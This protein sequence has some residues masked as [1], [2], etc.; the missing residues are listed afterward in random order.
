LGLPDEAIAF[1]VK[2]QEISTLFESDHYLYF[3]SLAGMGYT[4]FFTGDSKKA[5]EVGKT[6]LD[7]GQKHSNIRSQVVGHYIMGYGYYVG[8][9][10]PK[11]IE[12]CQRAIRL[13]TDPLYSQLPKIILG[14]SYLLN[15]QFEDAKKP[16]EE[17]VTFSKKFG[18]EL[19]ETPAR[20]LLAAI[21]IAEGHMSSGLTKLKEIQGECLKNQRKGVYVMFEH[22]LGKIYLQI[23]EGPSPSLSIVIKN[24]G[25]LIK[26]VPFAGRKAE[27]HLKKAIEAAKEIGAKGVL[28]QAY[29]D[30]GLLHKIKRRNE[31]ARECIS[32]AIKIFEQCE[33]EVY[34]KQAKEALASLE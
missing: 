17:Y 3:K 11:A 8:G 20:A 21:A 30:L 15:G 23:L 25:F 26:N 5:L 18:F 29:L 6:L 9:D 27:Y 10:S 34:F 19:G 4:Y 7:Y 16:L 28:G 33:A 24:I 22:M 31:K 14:S 13:T 12:C 32:E 1:G 2:A